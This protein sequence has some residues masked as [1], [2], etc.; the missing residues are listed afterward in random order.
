MLFQMFENIHLN[1]L[2]LHHNFLHKG[3]KQYLE[4]DYLHLHPMHMCK[5]LYLQLELFQQNHHTQLYRKYQTR[6]NLI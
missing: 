2:L 6:Y 3:W 4:F 1:P 5:V